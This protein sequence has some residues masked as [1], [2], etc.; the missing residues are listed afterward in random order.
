MQNIHTIQCQ[1][2]GPDA[3]YSPLKPVCCKPSIESKSYCEDHVWLVY[4]KGS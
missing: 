2:T 3:E 4:Q 1:W